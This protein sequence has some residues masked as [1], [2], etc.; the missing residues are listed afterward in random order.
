MLEVIVLIFFLMRKFGPDFSRASY[1]GL[2]DY[3]VNQENKRGRLAWT[4]ILSAALVGAAIFYARLD[5][6]CAFLG[7]YYVALAKDPFAFDQNNPVSYRLL[8][9]LLS[10]LVGFRGRGGLILTN[11][12]LSGVLVGCVYSRYRKISQQAGDAFLAAVIVTF[13]LVVLT[14]LYCGGYCDIMSYLL[15]FLMWRYRENRPAFYGLFLLGLL[16]RESVAFLVPWFTFL[17]MD[18]P[19]SRKAKILDTVIGFGVTF[20]A[21]YLFRVWVDS[22]QTVTFSTERYLG[23]FLKEPLNMLRWTLDWQPIGLFSV[24]KA[25]WVIPCLAAVSWIQRREYR[26]LVGV[27]LLFVGAY[28]QLFMA[29]DTSRM[30]TL[31]FMV[32][33]VSLDHLLKADRFRLRTW[34]FWA[35]LF[36]LLIPQLYT[37]GN[38]IEVWH[39]LSTW[40]LLQLW[41]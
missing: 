24:F 32:M 26:Q 39:S 41:Q 33:F 25:L 10:W 22:H 3:L 1:A 4:A 6:Q 5:T 12:L 36:N 2:N 37:A 8:T 14:S 23:G 34:V 17:T 13:S 18:L 30:F 38:K 19:G 15:I 29:W 40:A 9:P 7:Q 28:A 31:S 20:G 16:N 21:Y 11:L 35:V 27:A